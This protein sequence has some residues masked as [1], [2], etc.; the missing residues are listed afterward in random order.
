MRVACVALLLL[1]ILFLLV[2]VRDVEAQQKVCCSETLSG[3]HCDYVPS[4]ECQPSALM[5]A[6]ACE[7][8]SFCKLGCGY[9]QSS[10]KCFKNT[11]KFSCEQQGNCSWSASAQC[12]IPQCTRGCCVLSNECSFVTQLQC[13]KATSLYPDVQ[14]TFKEEITSELECINQCRSFERGACVNADGSCVFTTRESCPE[15]T[16]ESLNVTGPLA[17]FHPGKL[18]SH[19]QLGTEC[20]PQQR[21]GCLPDRDEVYWFDSCGNPENIYDSNKVRSFNNGF[22]SD[23]AQS[24]NSNSNNV[25]NPDCGNCDYPGGSLCGLAELGVNPTFGDYACV[26][27]NCGTDD[28][29][30]ETYS[31]ASTSAKKLGEG[32]CAYD[33]VP[34]GGQDPVGSRHYRRLCVN[35]RELT[36]SCKDFREEMCVQGVA[37]QPPFSTGAAFTLSQGSF[38]SAACRDNRWKSCTDAKNEFDCVNVQQRDCLWLGK[39]VYS[40]AQPGNP[41]AD[42]KAKANKQGKCVPFVPPGL[43]FWPD[44]S[45]GQTPS[46]DAKATC[47]KANAEC[48]V[49]YEE[50]GFGGR[51]CVANC[52]CEN[53]QWLLAQ[54]TICVAQGDCGAWVNIR[55]KGTT[56]GFTISPNHP[57]H[58]TGSDLNSFG[59]TV[60]PTK[61]SAEYDNKF[62]TFFKKSLFPLGALGIEYLYARLT[63]GV[64]WPFVGPLQGTIFGGWFNP[65]SIAKNFA[66][67][68]FENAALADGWKAASTLLEK[69]ASMDA[70]EKAVAD[71]VSDDFAKAFVENL[72]EKGVT[73]AEEAYHTT[74]MQEKKL[75]GGGS[76][77]LPY[78]N[79][80]LWL[81]TFY[82][83]LDVL[84]AD[85]DEITYSVHCEPWVA[86]VGGDDCESCGKDGKECSEY[87]CRSLGQACKLLNPGTNKE[88]CASAHPNDVTAPVIT[89]DPGALERGYTL[90]EKLGEGY[91]V[92]PQIEP[93]TAVSLGIKT[94]EPSQCK[95]SLNHS[96]SYDQMVGYF[97]DSLYDYNHTMTFSIPSEFAQNP[98][99]L[100]LTNGGQY[101]TYIRCQDGNGNKNER[102]YYIK[103]AV[104]KGPDLTPPVIE[105]T[106]IVNGAYI[107]AG[108]NSTAFVMYVNEPSECK[109]DDLDAD[110]GTMTHD[111]TCTTQSLPTSSL[112]YGLYE[113][114][115][116]LDDLE[117]NKNNVYYFRCK[118]QPGKP[119]SE[120]NVNEESY[121][122]SLR[123]TIPLEITSV[124]PSTG[125]QLM[126]QSPEVKVITARGAQNGLAVCGYSFVDN[127]PANA[128]DF[129]N[130]NSTV[131]TQLFTDLAAG[132]YTAYLSC[133]DAAGN[134]AQTQTSFSV[135]V[136]TGAP[137]IAQVYTEGSLLVV[138]MHEISTCEYSTTGFFSFGSGVQM[139]GADSTVH[140]APLDSD[141][142]YLVC[143][144]SLGNEGRYT[145]FV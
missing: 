3:S 28:I 19:P 73:H 40:N 43:K 44:Q 93:F 47:E 52:E 1:G 20:A 99:I 124:S 71:E 29:T 137:L 62:S 94:N 132:S 53:K 55:G 90:S 51:K 117:S 134:L 32:W 75:L 4:N 84:L 139:T 128:I 109:W 87:R 141:V 10:G 143:Q 145:I 41:D 131:H 135:S 82:N 42:T 34:G 46:A 125:S 14:M 21:T 70:I 49:V 22:V 66:V 68:A 48:T 58:L 100:K 101:T 11:P 106:G 69:G 83:L 74:F 97:G 50:G 64:G 16:P 78:L 37:G 122:Y 142:Y 59:Q 35:G 15:Q 98:D 54:N 79:T 113:C 72:R 56:H 95:F 5:A 123:G 102:D 92:S 30:Q 38:L 18:C 2:G 13:K 25:N 130:T 23:K 7:Q 115:T 63:F 76:E 136:D 57:Y 8:T 133:A 111:F 96:M 6:T 45:T 81:W 108:V 85:T 144:D 86:P 112:F 12:D 116:I 80:L 91:V 138:Q 26:D 121:V 33:S 118:D 140:E 119:E 65:G 89:A 120:R 88:V 31:P 114:A 126:T 110:F 107:P 129:V 67:G 27:V 24:C 103:F 105:A 127:N 17:G 9:D 77:L 61:G 36:E 104:K 60:F 39:S